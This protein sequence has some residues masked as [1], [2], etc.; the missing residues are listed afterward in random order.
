MKSQISVLLLVALIGIAYAQKN[1][2]VVCATCPIS[3]CASGYSFTITGSSFNETLCV[4]QGKTCNTGVNA[5][6]QLNNCSVDYL[7]TSCNRGICLYTLK[8]VS[9][10]GA[11]CD[12]QYTETI[13][14]GTCIANAGCGS[15]FCQGVLKP[16]NVNPQIGCVSSCPNPA[17]TTKTVQ[18]CANGFD[19]IGG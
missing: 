9:L 11:T 8:P 5:Q 14:C 19:A 17:N 7:S 10:L 2:T 4:S 16:P 18:A 6:F 1:V 15:S 3:T 13:T 12:T